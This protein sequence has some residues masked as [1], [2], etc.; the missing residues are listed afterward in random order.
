MNDEYIDY[1]Q[2]DSKVPSEIMAIHIQRVNEAYGKME[3][4]YSKRWSEMLDKVV[5]AHWTESIE[6][7]HF[8]CIQY[9]LQHLKTKAEYLGEE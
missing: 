2:I 9:G 1:I 6:G 4:A 3:S 5:S 7:V 8:S